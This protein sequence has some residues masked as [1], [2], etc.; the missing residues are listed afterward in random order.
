MHGL[1]GGERVPLLGREVS[2]S[3]THLLG[4]FSLCM[5]HFSSSV[6]SI[7]YFFDCPCEFS[8]LVFRVLIF[9]GF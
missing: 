1:G 5:S 7:F 8:I 2:S 4:F 3:M 9:V 6:C